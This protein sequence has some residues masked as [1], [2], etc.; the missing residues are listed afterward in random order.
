MSIISGAVIPTACS[1]SE[2]SDRSSGL[3]ITSPF[4]SVYPSLAI[5]K[6]CMADSSPLGMNFSTPLYI[7]P[8]CIN[9]T[10][11]ANF[12]N[13]PNAGPAAPYRVFAVDAL[14]EKSM[15]VYGRRLNT[16]SSPSLVPNPTYDNGP[17]SSILAKSLS[18][19]SASTLSIVQA[20]RSSG[21]SPPA[22]PN[23]KAARFISGKP[24]SPAATEVWNSL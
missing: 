21:S 15:S 4:F 12:P 20:S 2:N 17:R 18:P 7:S 8:R 3:T 6:L 22:R 5:R 10:P 11:S 9:P 14:L 19:T 16:R 13:C 1:A 24:S 23:A